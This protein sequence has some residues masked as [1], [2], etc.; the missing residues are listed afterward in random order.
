M[1]ASQDF[2]QMPHE[3]DESDSSSDMDDHRLRKDQLSS[4]GDSDDFCHGHKDSSDYS[5]SYDP[6]N[7]LENVSGED[8]AN[9]SPMDRRKKG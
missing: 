7:N 1:N 5:D 2:M 8:E 6:D 3:G 9:V 4:D